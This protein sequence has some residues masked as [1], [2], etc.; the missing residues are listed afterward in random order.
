MAL[1]CRDPR[2]F[3]CSLALPLFLR[4]HPS[5][6]PFVRLSPSL[7]RSCVGSLAFPIERIHFARFP[8]SRIDCACVQ[9]RRATNR[10]TKGYRCTW[11]YDRRV[12]FDLTVLLLSTACSFQ[13]KLYRAFGH[14]MQLSV[15]FESPFASFY[16]RIS[17]AAGWNASPLVHM[18]FGRKA[19]KTRRETGLDADTRRGWNVTPTGPNE[20]IDGKEYTARRTWP[21]HGGEEGEEWRGLPAV[22][23]GARF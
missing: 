4:A 16:P 22:E 12:P 3:G 23:G 8:F 7:P 5:S 21:K 17:C 20:S 13:R 11:N 15:R 18:Q 1:I 6:Y 19:C 2:R 14:C 10:T 9:S